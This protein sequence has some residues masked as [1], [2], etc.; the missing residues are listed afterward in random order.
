MGYQ[1]TQINDLIQDNQLLTT[2]IL[3]DDENVMPEIRLDK[4]FNINENTNK[5]IDNDKIIT[6][7]FYE[8]Q[9]LNGEASL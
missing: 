5:V 7:L 3:V 8:N 6:C 4:S 9:F 2:F 1:V